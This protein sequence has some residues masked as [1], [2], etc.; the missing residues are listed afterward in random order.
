MAGSVIE[1][2]LTRAAADSSLDSACASLLSLVVRQASCLVPSTQLGSAMG[3][4]KAFHGDKLKAGSPKTFA[5]LHDETA[6]KHGVESQL[7]PPPP[8]SVAQQRLQVRWQ[9]L[10]LTLTVSACG[11]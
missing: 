7:V 4:A 10:T 3:A 5:A 8:P 6:V 9:P 2:L 1:L 11:T